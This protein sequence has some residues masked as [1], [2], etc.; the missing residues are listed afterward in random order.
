V[1]LRRAHLWVGLLA[2]AAFIASGVH[3]R[4][5]LQQL[6]DGDAGLRY[7]HRANHIYILCSGLVNLVLGAYLGGAR[8]LRLQALGSALVLLAPVLLAAAFVR[9][10]GSGDIARPLTRFGVIALAVGVVLVCLA[11]GRGGATS[12]STPD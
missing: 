2:L 10:P 12:C 4:F 5:N 6:L 3:M 9:E 11:R 1:T 8:R 7:A